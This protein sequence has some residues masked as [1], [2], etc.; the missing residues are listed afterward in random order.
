MA[1]TAEKDM[2]KKNVKN[3]N[4][5]Q[6]HVIKDIHKN[7]D[8]KRCKFSIYCFYEHIVRTD[9]VLEEL[10]LVKEKLE[11]IENEIEKKN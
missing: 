2:S 7:A 10:K 1:I 6:E 9:P 3:K 11:V 4:V 5:I 8:Y